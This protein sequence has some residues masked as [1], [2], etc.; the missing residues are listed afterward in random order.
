[1]QKQIFSLI[2]LFV[3]TGT[4]LIALESEPPMPP[5][6]STVPLVPTVEEP[7]ARTERDRLLDNL[8]QAIDDRETRIRELTDRSTGDLPPAGV[9]DLADADEDRRN[10][11]QAWHLLEETLADL[12]LEHRRQAD[13]LDSPATATDDYQV[14]RLRS[15]NRLFMARSYKALLDQGDDPQRDDIEQGFDIIRA[16][17]IEHLTDADRP[18]RAY[19]MFWFATEL[20]RVSEGEDR[21]RFFEAARN[22][23]ER[24]TTDWPGSSSLVI[25]ATTLFEQLQQIVREDGGMTL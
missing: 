19:L 8:R 7:A 9:A 3:T 21:H 6:G 12:A 4:W 24:L 16:V 15:R 11:D 17:P 2:I 18:L 1:M 14:E 5:R 22:A 13:V 10:R 25:S 23:Y 20:T